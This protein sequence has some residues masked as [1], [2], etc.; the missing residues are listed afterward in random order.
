MI[1]EILKNLQ[2]EISV[3][4]L[5]VAVA[6]TII[7]VSHS[8]LETSEENKSNHNSTLIKVKQKYY[9]A[10]DRK[11]LLEEFQTRYTQL[12]SAGIATQEER[13]NWID[14]IES[15]TKKYDIPF[16][17]YKISKQ[18]KLDSNNLSNR[19]P[20]ID[21]F[22]ST[23]TLE[24][25]LLHE[26][27]LFTIINNLHQSAKGLFDIGECSITKNL[28]QKSSLLDKDTDKNFASICTL[29]W[30]TMQ[31]KKVVLPTRRNINA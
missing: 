23:M 3:F 20:G 30:Y 2:K 14:T 29:N 9:T 8:V 27:D 26:G 15:I 6:T 17:K 19:F 18:T 4:L 21:I 12:Q 7:V 10:L 5:S 22:K 1:I 13:L 25:Q 11:R 16:L 28:S 31:K 24:T